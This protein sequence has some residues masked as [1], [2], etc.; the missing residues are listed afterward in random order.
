MA[1]K[2]SG[3]KGK[4]SGGSGKNHRSAVTGRFVKES[5]AK[6]DPDRTVSERRK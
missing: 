3:G 1:R 5:T 2:G 6:R 4:S